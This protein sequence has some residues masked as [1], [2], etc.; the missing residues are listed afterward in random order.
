MLAATARTAAMW[1][2]GA[3]TRERDR[4]AV[5]PIGVR[6]GG[7]SPER[8]GRISILVVWTT[9]GVGPNRHA[10]GPA[11]PY[12]GPWQ[13]GPRDRAVRS[14]ARFARRSSLLQDVP[15]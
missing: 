15:E 8:P 3:T 2:G 10:Q 5:S 9:N 4:T 14:P 13:T 1:R 11:S 6:L 7:G 12:T